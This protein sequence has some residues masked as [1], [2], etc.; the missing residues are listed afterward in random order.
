MER[1]ILHGYSNEGNKRGAPFF[2]KIPKAKTFSEIAVKN[3]ELKTFPEKLILYAVN[4]RKGPMSPYEK[5]HISPFA[6]VN[7]E[8]LKLPKTL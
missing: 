2:L 8:V 6:S 5:T 1:F 4:R 7:G 3:C